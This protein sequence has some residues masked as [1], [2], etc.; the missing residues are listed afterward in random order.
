MD[1]LQ[2]LL[3]SRVKAEIFRLLFG[4]ADGELH[5][6]E[7]GRRAGLADATVRQ[8]LQRLGRL[9]LVTLRRSG[10]RVYCR[11]HR[12]HPLYPEIHHLVL[13]TSGLVDVLKESLRDE[14]I[15]LAIVF[16]SVAAGTTTA[17]SDVDLMI[18]GDIGLRAV[19]RLL[20]GVNAVVGREL[21]PVVLSRDEFVRRRE[22][23]DHLVTSVLKGP[24]LFVIG[25]D[26]DL[27]GMG[28]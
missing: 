4:V 23:S 21:N 26:D 8:E 7:I 5:I 24:R 27:A 10:D 9:G 11:A 16:G 22:A 17:F 19:T 14:R 6:R 28:G 20:S 15:R 13:K 1:T 3:S 12:E 18:V 25:D 2:D